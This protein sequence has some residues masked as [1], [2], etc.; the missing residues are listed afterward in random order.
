MLLTGDQERY[1]RGGPGCAFPVRDGWWK[2]PVGRFLAGEIS[3]QQLEQSLPQPPTNHS[4]QPDHCSCKDRGGSSPPSCG[5]APRSGASSSGRPKC[6]PR[7][8]D[9]LS[10]LGAGRGPQLSRGEG[11]APPRTARSRTTHV[12]SSHNCLEGRAPTH[13]PPAPRLSFMLPGQCS[14]P[15]LLYFPPFN[16]KFGVSVDRHTVVC[17]SDSLLHFLQHRTPR[18]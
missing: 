18:A 9:I 6:W 7:V 5:C 2:D 17:D 15:S 13:T 4:T 16:L 12:L 3:Q 8:L 1:Q 14:C 11:T 10:Y